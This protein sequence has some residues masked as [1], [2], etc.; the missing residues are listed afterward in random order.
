[1]HYTPLLRN[2][3]LQ[4]AATACLNDQC[5]LC[6]LAYVFDMLQKAEASTCQAGNMLKALS[7]QPQGIDV[8]GSCFMV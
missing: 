6:E 1:M 2:M 7:H 3:A 8:E 5:M 4:H